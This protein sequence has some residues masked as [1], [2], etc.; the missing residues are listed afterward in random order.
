[1]PKFPP[2]VKQFLMLMVPLI[3]STQM[4][5]IA[6][7]CE[8]I[9]L[10]YPALGS[11]IA[12]VQ[13]ELTWDRKTSGSYRVQIVVALPE[14]RVLSS[15]D[16]TTDENR[17]KLPGAVPSSLAS[18]KV[19]VSQACPGLDAQDVNAQGP[20]F[21]INTRMSCTVSDSGVKQSVNRLTWDPVVRAE[22][23][24]VRLFELQSDQVGP[25]HTKL[26]AMTETATPSWSIPPSTETV[27]GQSSLR[28]VLRV[29]T[30]QPIC[31]GLTGPVHASRLQDSP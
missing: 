31:N 15:F 13:P 9:G 8:M 19:L 1:M 27:P 2:L 23:Y 25:A 11:Q 26:V 14:A 5:A 24:W 6:S 29:A 20:A 21:F 7:A 18:V 28:N 3:C 17:F 30:V 4:T 22:R 10:T 12:D 16:V